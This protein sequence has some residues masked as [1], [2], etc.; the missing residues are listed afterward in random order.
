MAVLDEAG[1][2]QLW[3]ALGNQP[4]TGASH[5]VW[6]L[7]RLIP[8]AAQGRRPAEPVVLSAPRPIRRVR[9]GISTH[10]DEARP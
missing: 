5:A 1:R 4:G 2:M 8:R 3:I 9:A 6:L 7:S 10:R